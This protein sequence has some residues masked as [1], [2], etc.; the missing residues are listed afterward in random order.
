M[1]A[2]VYTYIKLRGLGL[3]KKH[4]QYISWSAEAG[5]G[6]GGEGAEAAF[7]RLPIPRM[8]DDLIALLFIALSAFT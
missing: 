7:Q 8:L 3:L 5:D 6:G 1:Y 4:F 2:C